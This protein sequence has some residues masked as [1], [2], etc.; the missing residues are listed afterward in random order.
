MPLPSFDG[1]YNEW[2]LYKDKFSR[3]KDIETIDDV[4]RLHYLK[5]SLKG[6]AATPPFYLLP[7][8]IECFIFLVLYENS[9][10]KFTK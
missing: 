5:E 7:F 1:D 4:Q 9:N 8:Y 2:I 10:A 3:I 6:E